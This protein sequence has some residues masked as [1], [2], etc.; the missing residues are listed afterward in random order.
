MAKKK[1]KPTKK[2]KPEK[3]FSS[4][5]DKKRKLKFGNNLVSPK[6]DL[7]K[8]GISY[9]MIS[10]FLECRERFRLANVEAWTGPHLM[11]P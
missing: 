6:W 3:R 2:D 11:S 4:M 9:S 7:H 10:R 5:W 1:R 8:H